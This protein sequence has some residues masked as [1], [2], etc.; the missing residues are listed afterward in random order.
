VSVSVILRS[1]AEADIHQALEQLEAIRTGLG[2][3]FK[4][5]LCRLLERVE[6]MPEM[7]GIV[8]QDVRAARLREFRYVVYYIALP[9]RVEV[10]AVLHGRR[11]STH[12]QSRK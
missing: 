7:Y 5:S 2:Q 1:E 11:D 10:L 3:R 6:A 12:W 9:D 8:W 4:G